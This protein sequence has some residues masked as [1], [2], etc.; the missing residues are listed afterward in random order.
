MIL[1]PFLGSDDVDMSPRA[2]NASGSSSSDVRASS[3]AGG[4]SCTSKKS[5]GLDGLPTK[6]LIKFS[7]LYA[8]SAGNMLDAVVNLD[9]SSI[10]GAWKTFWR[11]GEATVSLLS[12][13]SNPDYPP[14][15][16]L[17]N[18]HQLSDPGGL[19]C[20]LFPCAPSVS[21]PILCLHILPYISTR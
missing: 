7:I 14:S 19:E 1:L 9:F 12:V 21:S 2:R 18:L 13:Y 15:H 5:S 6:D 10:A 11:T 8:Q 20:C 4:S 3:S 17:I 16:R